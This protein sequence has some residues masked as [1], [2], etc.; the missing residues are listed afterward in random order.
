MSLWFPLLYFCREQAF[1]PVRFYGSWSYR[2]PRCQ[3][4]KTAPDKEAPYRWLSYSLLHLPPLCDPHTDPPKA[5]SPA[6]FST[7]V[8]GSW[9]SYCFSSLAL[10]ARSVTSCAIFT[11]SATSMIIYWF[12]SE[13]ALKTAF[14]SAL[15]SAIFKALHISLVDALFDILHH[16]LIFVNL[17]DSLLDF[18]IN[19]WYY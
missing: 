4:I 17:K 7:G 13:S 18:F 10:I 16:L 19:N 5:L 1:P 2:W 6:L 15:L 8:R 11:L 12:F 14:I 3:K 9:P